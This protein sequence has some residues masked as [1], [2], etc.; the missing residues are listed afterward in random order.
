MKNQYVQLDRNPNYWG[1]AIGLTPQVDQIIYRI[2][3]NQDAEAAA[4]PIGEIDFGYFDSA[5]ILNTLKTK[6][7]ISR[8]EAPSS[9][10]STRS[11]STRAPRIRRTRRAGSS[12]HGDGAPALTDVPLRQAMRSAIDS[13]TL[14]DKV[15]LGYG[16]PGI[17]PV[18]PGATTGDWQP[19][20]NDPDLSFNIAN[21]NAMLD[22]A[23]YTMGL[24]QRPRRPEV[25][26]AARVPLLQPRVGPDHDRHRPVRA[27]MDGA[28]RDQARR[29]DASTATSWQ[30]DPR[31]RDYDLFD[32][33][34]YPNPDP[35]Y[36][37]D[38]FTCA[39]ASAGRRH[40][41]ELR[42]LLLQ[43]RVRQA[44]QAAT[45]RVIDPAKRVDIVHQM[46]SILYRIQPYMVLWNGALLEA[47]RSADW[48]GFQPQ[49]RS[50]H[51]DVLATYGPLSFISIHPVSGTSAGRGGSSS[52]ISAGGVVRDPGG[53]SCIIVGGFFDRTSTARVATRTKRNDR[54]TRRRGGRTKGEHTPVPASPRSSRRCSPCC[55]S[56]CSTSSSSAG[57][58]TRRS[59]SR[60][61]EGTSPRPPWNSSGRSSAW[62]CRSRS[63][64]RTTSS[65][66]PRATSG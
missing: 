14:V 62:T 26:Q 64:S 3:G 41:P 59:C 18:Q 57:S 48:T 15:L 24:G 2:Y 63:S 25:R 19:G 42:Q 37:L 22:Q 49:P 6:P 5:N 43:P 56:W 30:R 35:N 1:N 66:P 32:W 9:R 10:A 47:Y 13:Q 33:G 44:E 17:S 28:D 54:V 7:G 23:G 60:S 45:V 27:R 11:D 34:W 50:G 46:Q 51:G 36:I 53:G 16:S 58:A 52:G 4:L 31:G 8:P 12:P 40:V 20:P 21:A 39:A 61:S 65:R 38:I 55:S 29:A